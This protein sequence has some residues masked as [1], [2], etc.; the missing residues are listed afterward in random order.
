MKPLDELVKAVA[1]VFGAAGFRKSGRRY[2]LMPP[3]GAPGNAVLAAFAPF[4]GDP[5]KVGFHL[6]WAVIPSAAFAFHAG[7]KSP[8]ITW[9]VIAERVPAPAAFVTGSATELWSYPVSE[10][11]DRCAA[12][13]TEVLTGGLLDRLLAFQD[14]DQVLQAIDEGSLGIGLPTE[15]PRGRPWRY[16]SMHI[17][18]ADPSDLEPL[19]NQLQG[20]PMG[21]PFQDWWRERLAARS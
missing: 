7:S 1:P 8:S 5:A 21:N 9:G 14:P 4:T 19:L 12:A 20:A 10:G 13:I 17:D 18:D 3:A 6:E 16:L 2:L 11:P 15:I